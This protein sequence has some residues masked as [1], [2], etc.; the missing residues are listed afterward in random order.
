MYP[1][2]RMGLGHVLRVRLTGMQLIP[3]NPQ[4]DVY[5]QLTTEEEN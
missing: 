1:P 2:T 3:R 4:I 5:E